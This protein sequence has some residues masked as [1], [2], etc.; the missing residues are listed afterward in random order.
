VAIKV[1]EEYN[2]SMYHD[3]GDRKCLR[4]VRNYLPVCKP[5]QF[6]GPE[7][8]LIMHMKQQARFTTEQEHGNILLLF[9]EFRK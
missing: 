1:E 5:S 9:T 2:A 6:R 7:L 8:I 4:N 3:D